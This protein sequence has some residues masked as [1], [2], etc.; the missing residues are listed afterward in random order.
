MK[1]L[2]I[3]PGYDRLGV[4]VI[5]SVAGK[6]DTLL[7]STCLT[8][9]KDDEF[10]ERLWQ[11]AQ[12]VGKIIKK[13]SP[14]ILALEKIFFATNQKTAIKVAEVRGV[15]S[16]LA[17]QFNLT[18]IN[19]APLEV[20][21]AITGYGQASK[22]QVKRMVGLMIKETGSIKSD[23]EIDAVAMALAGASRAVAIYPQKSAPLF[24]KKS[25]YGRK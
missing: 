18:L 20:K 23:D 8:T 16:Y 21:L 11:L 2:G 9:D 13:Y 14:D 1:I 4:A 24:A 12:A 7:F 5:E 10:S 19:L 25:R 17:R 22:D 6:K 15:I 3:D